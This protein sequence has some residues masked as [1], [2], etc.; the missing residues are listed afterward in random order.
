MKSKPFPKIDKSRSKGLIGQA[1][2]E[3][4]IL[5]KYNWIYHPISQEKDFGI[6][7][8]IEIV[9]DGKATAK[10]IAVQ[11][12]YGDSYFKNEKNGKIAFYGEEKHLNY[13]ANCNVP[14]IIVLINDD[15]SK[16]IWVRF[17]IE[18][19]YPAKNGWTIEIPCDNIFNEIDI[20]K[21]AG[22]II[23][24]S[25]EINSLWNI[26]EILHAAS[27]YLLVIP[28]EDVENLDYTKITSIIKHLS[29]NSKV[30]KEKCQTMDICFYG[31]DEDPR[32]LFEIREVMYWMKKSLDYK[33]PWFYFLSTDTKNS[34]MVL[35]I[36]ALC[37]FKDTEKIN[38]RGNLLFFPG[39]KIATFFE[40][41]FNIL[42]EFMEKHGLT[43]EL[44][45]KISENIFNRY[46]I[47]C[48]EAEKLKNM[49]NFIKG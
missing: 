5:T 34:A 35:L 12:K 25:E 8:H 1:F 47:D 41:N 2:F 13:Y 32:E 24:Y 15:C 30:L 31:Y 10:L 20:E 23:D 16:I 9:K 46:N 39:E 48:E 36:A 18:L 27:A 3:N 22:P 7:G 44:N 45:K 14:V 19:T 6:D 33:I 26:D 17:D 43:L 21:L 28:K 4:L 40:I 37:D 49:G 42:N 29:K 11:I 38:N